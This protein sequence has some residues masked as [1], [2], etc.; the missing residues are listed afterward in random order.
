MITIDT[1]CRNEL[2][3]LNRL[4]FIYIRFAS[5]QVGPPCSS[6][7]LSKIGEAAKQRAFDNATSLFH[8]D[9]KRWFHPIPRVVPRTIAPIRLFVPPTVPP[10]SD[11]GR[12]N[13]CSTSR[14]GREEK[15]K[16]KEKSRR[17]GG[18]KKSFDFQVKS[19][20]C[21][22]APTYAYTFT[23]CT[24]GA[25]MNPCGSI[26]GVNGRCDGSSGQDAKPC[27]I[28]WPEEIARLLRAPSARPSF[29]DVQGDSTNW[30]G[31]LGGVVPCNRRNAI[32]GHVYEYSDAETLT[33]NAR[34]F[35]VSSVL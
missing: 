11:L 18:R 22:R 28:A 15:E 24:D 35:I 9:L 27:S 21:D 29:L 5:V 30:D 17:S 23:R 4:T 10:S 6:A 8:P 32:Q 20:S 3:L 2:K 26:S 34:L 33:L 13:R 12:K 25:Q 19:L 31:V 14:G 7:S 16:K 1:H